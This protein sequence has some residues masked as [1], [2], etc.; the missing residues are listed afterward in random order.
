VPYFPFV[1]LFERKTYDLF[2]A[3]GIVS[4]AGWFR[5]ALHRPPFSSFFLASSDV[6]DHVAPFSLCWWNR[7]P[8]SQNNSLTRSRKTVSAL[9]SFVVT[10]PAPAA[11][12]RARRMTGTSFP[13]RLF[14]PAC[15]T[16]SP[17]TMLSSYCFSK[18]LSIHYSLCQF[19]FSLRVSSQDL[20]LGRFSIRPSSLG[21]I[22]CTAGKR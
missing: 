17:L 1:S 22:T 10:L 7:L 20:I 5:S 8:Y 15:T 16:R 2:V 12:S 3:S 13:L 19:F 4:F 21:L 18:Y 14:H 6:Q 9:R 11:P